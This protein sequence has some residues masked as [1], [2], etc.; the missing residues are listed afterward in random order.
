MSHGPESSVGKGA[1][2]IVMSNI[3]YT[4]PGIRKVHTPSGSLN[5]LYQF[6]TALFHKLEQPIHWRSRF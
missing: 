5:L 2:L 6:Q 4:P 3:S 1:Q